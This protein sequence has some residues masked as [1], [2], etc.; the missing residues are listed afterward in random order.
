M[1]QE[2]WRLQSPE[3]LQSRWQVFVPTR[4][5]AHARRGLRLRTPML[6]LRGRQSETMRSRRLRRPVRSVPVW[7]LRQWQLPV[8]AELSGE[9]VRYQ[10]RLWG[11][12]WLPPGIHLC[13]RKL[14]TH[15]APVRPEL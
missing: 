2:L 3:K 13:K 15:T 12:M 7:Q 5:G 8:Y 9:L 6:R 1:R 4:Y 11:H 10:R 14:H